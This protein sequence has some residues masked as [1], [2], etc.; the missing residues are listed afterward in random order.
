[1]PSI[2]VIGIPDGWSSQQLVEAFRARG[3]TCRLFDMERVVVD[4]ETGT[5]TCDGNDLQACD[6]LVLKKIG[7]PYSPHMLDRLGALEFLAE[8]GLP[9]FSHPRR[10]RRVLD[11]LSCTAGLRAADIPMPP[12]IVTEDIDC[13]AQA[14]Q[15]FGRAVL[16]PI[17]TSKARGMV[18]VE[19]SDDARAVVERYRAAGNRTLYVQKM[20]RLPGHDLGLVFAGGERIGAYARVGSDTSWNTTTHSGGRYAACEPDAEIIDLAR[21]AQAPFELDFTCVDIAVTEVGP[22]V[23]EVSAFGGFRGLRDACG[24]DAAGLYAEHVL[25]R[26]NHG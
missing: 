8:G 20:L 7:T 13:A 17:Y 6:A 12:T 3:C 5:G 18:V 1:M 26:L 14:A 2:G 9:V 25:R 22:V 23:F 21:R 19:E 11:R 24:I 4:F 15:R 10:V 16:K